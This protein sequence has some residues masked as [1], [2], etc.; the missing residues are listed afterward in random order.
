M[1][2]YANERHFTPSVNSISV[3][4]LYND[5]Y[6]VIIFEWD[7]TTET[8]PGDRTSEEIAG[9][10]PFK[11]AVSVQFPGSIAGGSEKPSFAMGDKKRPVN[12][13]YWS[14]SQV[15][16]FIY[17]RFSSGS[18]WP[19]GNSSGSGARVKDRRPKGK[20]GEKGQRRQKFSTGGA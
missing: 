15:P 20:K 13:W 1:P 17:G 18:S 5:S 11:D 8:I 9:G 3:K 2:S 7:D 12:I 16:V 4:A 6:I 10:V 14:P 19:G